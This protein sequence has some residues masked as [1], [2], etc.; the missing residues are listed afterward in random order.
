MQYHGSDSTVPMM[1]C[2]PEVAGH[3]KVPWWRLETEPWESFIKVV[4][5]KCSTLSMFPCWVGTALPGFPTTEPAAS[6]HPLPSDLTLGRKEGDSQFPRL[7]GRLGPEPPRMCREKR[8]SNPFN[9]L[10]WSVF[11]SERWDSEASGQGPTLP[12]LHNPTRSSSS[13]S[14]HAR[15]KQHP[16]PKAGTSPVMFH[17]ICHIYQV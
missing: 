5:K 15:A 12:I 17:G 9:H 10:Y 13:V 16:H 6:L 4:F 8:C 14:A 3:R 11:P 2:T 1:M 7:W